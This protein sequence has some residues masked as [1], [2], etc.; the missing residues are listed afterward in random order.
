MNE[1]WYDIRDAYIETCEEVLG[2]VERNRKEWITDDTWRKIEERR[3]LKVDVDRARTRLEKRNAMQQYRI[4]GRQVKEACRRD[5]RAYI[6]QVAADAEEAASKG[7]LNRLYQTTRIL[8]GRKPNQN[9]PIRN[10]E[11]DIL[12][13]ADEQLARWKEHFEEVL[14]RPPPIHQP[15]LQPGEELPIKTENISRAEIRAAIKSL[16]IGKVTGIDNM[17]SEAIHA[18]GEVSVEALYKLLNK[19]WR[20]EQIP[21][22][23]KKGLLVKLPKKGDTTHCQNWR[24]VTLLVSAS[25]ILSRIILDRIKSTLDSLL[26]DEQAGFRHERSCTDQIATLRIIIEQSLEWNSGLFLAFIDFE[27]AFDSVDRE[28]MWQILQHYQGR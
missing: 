13:K 2:K 10:K 20:E 6:N 18:G 3:Q 5:K 8:S 24:G 1:D 16:K 19:I 12:A 7:D 9:K 4:K 26:R 23:W 25:K 15:V 17:P 11:G 22:E 27:K 14:N 21:D 28:A